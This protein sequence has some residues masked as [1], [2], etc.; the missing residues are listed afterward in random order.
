MQTPNR[1][2]EEK[3]LPADRL[4]EVNGGAAASE[5]PLTEQEK[6]TRILQDKFIAMLNTVGD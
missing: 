1:P 6:Q 4:V 5:A 3:A 2:D